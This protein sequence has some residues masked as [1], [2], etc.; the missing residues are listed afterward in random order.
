[1]MIPQSLGVVAII[2]PFNFPGMIPFWFFP[3]AIASGNTC[4]IKPSDYEQ[5]YLIRPTILQDINPRGEIARTEIFGPVLSLIHLNTREEASALI[6]IMVLKN[7]LNFDQ[8]SVN[9]DLST[10]ICRIGS[11]VLYCTA[12]MHENST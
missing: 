4:I 3:Y 1:M 8:K 6:K 5:G 9:T 2:S 10:D 11:T 7:I 12:R